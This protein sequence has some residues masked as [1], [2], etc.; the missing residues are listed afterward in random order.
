MTTNEDLE[1]IYLERLRYLTSID[2]I[3]EQ[4]CENQYNIACSI[5]TDQKIVLGMGQKN[6]IRAEIGTASA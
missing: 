2:N 4:I 5:G 6:D 3:L 1:E